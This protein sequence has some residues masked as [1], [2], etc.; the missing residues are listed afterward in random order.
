M[1][2]MHIYE[3]ECYFLIHIYNVW[4]TQGNYYIHHLKL[5]LCFVVSAFKILSSNYFEIYNAYYIKPTILL[6][7]R[8]SP[9]YLIIIRYLLNNFPHLPS[10][11]LSPGFDNLY[12]ILNFCEITD[13]DMSFRFCIWLRSC[14]VCLS[15]LDLFLFINVH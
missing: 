14:T 2:L 12:S 15:M 8:I 4:S 9:S 3:I 6:N 5:L 1:L 10:P 7:M 13:S 11:L